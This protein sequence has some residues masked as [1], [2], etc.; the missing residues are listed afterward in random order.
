MVSGQVVNEPGRARFFIAGGID[1]PA[2]L[3]E[4]FHYEM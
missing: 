4:I 2:F 1:A 3:M